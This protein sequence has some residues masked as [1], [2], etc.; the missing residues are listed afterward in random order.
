MKMAVLSAL[1]CG[2]REGMLHKM[3]AHAWDYGSVG[4]HWF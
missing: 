3:S 1:I 2:W 4:C